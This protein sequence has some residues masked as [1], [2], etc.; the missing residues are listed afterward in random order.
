M[1]QLGQIFDTLLSPVLSAS[2]KGASVRESIK[3]SMKKR[4][5]ALFSVAPAPESGPGPSKRE[6]QLTWRRFLEVVCPEGY[7]L[8]PT[9][10]DTKRKGGALR[11]INPEP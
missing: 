4:M 10:G 7:K 6:V 11:S 3:G 1:F 5:S 9:V 2:T 8:P